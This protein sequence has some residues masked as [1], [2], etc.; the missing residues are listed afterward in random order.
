MFK[1]VAL[2]LAALFVLGG[3][4]Y[5]AKALG[6]PEIANFL[7]AQAANFSAQYHA[8]KA[9]KAAQDAAAA[10]SEISTTTAQ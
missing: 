4:V 9:E 5:T 10:V 8:A 7:D 2:S 1:K 6:F 3:S